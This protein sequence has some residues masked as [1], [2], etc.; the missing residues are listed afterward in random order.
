MLIKTLFGKIMLIK[1]LGISQF[2]HLAS[3]LTIPEHVIICIER[4]IFNFLW[5][6]KGDKVKRSAVIKSMREGGLDMKTLEA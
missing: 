4:L 3:V 5:K 1:T 6:G 2:I